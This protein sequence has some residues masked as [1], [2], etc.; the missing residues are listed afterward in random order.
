VESCGLVQS[1]G[2]SDLVKTMEEVLNADS[3]LISTVPL[4]EDPVQVRSRGVLS[5]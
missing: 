3:T 1:G 5:P 4:V 2:D